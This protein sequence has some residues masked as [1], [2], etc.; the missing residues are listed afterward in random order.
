VVDL[1]E[2]IRIVELLAARREEPFVSRFAAAE[3]ARETLGAPGLARRLYQAAALEPEG[4]PWRG[5][6]AL[7]ALT[8]AVDP[9]TRWP[10]AELV[11]TLEDPYVA[12]ALNRYLP[13]DTLVRLEAALQP[14]LDSVVSWARL[15][16]RRR[17]VLIRTRT[18][19]G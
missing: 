14:R 8:L 4:G 11:Q 10:A 6:A 12:R 9:E 15:E 16:A 13:A 17:D 2:E 5:K 19:G 1:L 3:R 18:N 7:A